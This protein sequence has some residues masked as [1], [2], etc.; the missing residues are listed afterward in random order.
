MS[1]IWD[2]I[3]SWYILKLVFYSPSF[4]HDPFFIDPFLFIRKETKPL[5]NVSFSM[6][7]AAR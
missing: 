1:P 6:K 7:K 5:L 3:V 4:L 2:K